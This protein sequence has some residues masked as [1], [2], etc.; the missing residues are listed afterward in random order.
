M[1]Y[2]ETIMTLW[3]FLSDIHG[4]LR[5]L[6]AAE[7]RCRERQVDRYVCLGDVIGRGDPEGCVRW[8]QDR[9]TL[10]LVGNRDLDHLEWVRPD[11]R[12]VVLGW[13]REGAASDFLVTHGD[14]LFHRILNSR[15]EADGFRRAGAIMAQRG[16]RLWLYGHTHRARAWC[17]S[18]SGAERV[19]GCGLA[20]NSHQR[21]VVNVGTTGLPLP[22]RG[23]PSITLYDDGA[24]W[25][26]MVPLS[27][28]PQ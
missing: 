2:K 5:G 23:G 17:L 4:N 28:P 19:E 3:A 16:A 27:R 7:A 1:H 25:L 6:Q 21:Y 10:A 14:T 26:E 9:A 12:A 13:A 8:V 15:A 18:E 20:L 11:L 24:C 22:G